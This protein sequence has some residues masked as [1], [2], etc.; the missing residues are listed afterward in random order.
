MKK[1]KDMRSPK[2]LQPSLAAT[3][4]QLLGIG[5]LVEEMLKPG[6]PPEMLGAKR[7]LLHQM[8]TDAQIPVDPELQAKADITEY[9]VPGIEEKSDAPDVRVI[10]LSPK[11]R[12]SERLPVIFSLHGGG[13]C[14]G[15]PELEIG[16]LIHW[17]VELGCVCVAPSYRLAPENIY[18]AAVDDI[19]AALLWTVD[20]AQMLGVDP[21]LIVVEGMSSGG[22]LAAALTHRVK[23]RG[24]PELCAQVLEFP[25]LDDRMRESSSNIF[26]EQVWLPSSEQVMWK[27]W[28]GDKY[29][30]AD[31]PPDAVP[32]HARDF[33]GLPP[34][35]IHSAEIDHGRDDVIRYASSLMK[36]GV[37]CDLHIWGGAYHAFASLQ[38]EPELSRRYTDLLSM[39][40]K[41]A[42]TGKLVRR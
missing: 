31:T 29:V 21:S 18:P 3:A 20:S 37:Y 13:L 35:I 7:R 11:E 30:R 4:Y 1:C 42:L 23:D 24:G 15:F 16:K 36:A 9:F 27:A 39:Q 19:Y 22:H 25:P 40:L 12:P 10:V 6:T 5:P 14:M 17:A 34:A 41:D 26:F 32:G 33:Q 2:W 8:I 38:P 28:L